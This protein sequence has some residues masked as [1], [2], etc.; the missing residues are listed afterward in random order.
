[1]KALESSAIILQKLRLLSAEAMTEWVTEAKYVP[2]V[3][4]SLRGAPILKSRQAC[5]F[6]HVWADMLHY[7]GFIASP[8]MTVAMYMPHNYIC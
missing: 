8:T 5:L 2:R 6:S 1:M 4:V 7:W 3:K